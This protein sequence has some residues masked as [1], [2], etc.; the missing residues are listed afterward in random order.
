MH[1]VDETCKKE[2]FENVMLTWVNLILTYGTLE[3]ISTFSEYRK[4]SCYI[5]TQLESF[6]TRKLSCNRKMV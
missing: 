6:L 1:S 3:T 5:I 2:T 4:Y